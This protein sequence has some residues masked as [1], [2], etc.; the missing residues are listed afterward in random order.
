MILIR[1]FRQRRLLQA[2]PT[3]SVR[4]GRVHRC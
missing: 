4:N 1:V 2:V 3:A